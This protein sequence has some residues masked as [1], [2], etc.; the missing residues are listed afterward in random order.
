MT[1]VTYEL[2]VEVNEDEVTRYDLN[3]LKEAL[4]DLVAKND[5]Y[6]HSLEVNYDED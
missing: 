2:N 4:E 5:F 1:I 3:K 6:L